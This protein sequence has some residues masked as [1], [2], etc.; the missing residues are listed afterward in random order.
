[1]LGSVCM[2][3]TGGK[4]CFT[5][6][7]WNCLVLKH[8]AAAQKWKGEVCFG[9]AKQVQDEGEKLQASGQ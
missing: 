3:K 6:P 5:V 8:S 9:T 1:M 7:C 2:L 4:R